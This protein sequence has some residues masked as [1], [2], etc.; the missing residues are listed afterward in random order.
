MGIEIRTVGRR[1]KYYLSH[2]YRANGEA[3]KVRVFLGTNL[4]AEEL[5]AERAGAAIRLKEKLVPKQIKRHK[6][7]KLVG[8]DLDGTLVYYPKAKSDFEVV[9]D[10]VG[11]LYYDRKLGNLYA[12]GKLSLSKWT[13]LTF[14]RYKERGLTQKK[15]NQTFK[16]QM[17]LI[18]GVR[19]L[20]EELKRR[21]I[22]V[23]IISGGLKNSYDAFVDKFGIE[24]DYTRFAHELVFDKKGRF[25]GGNYSEYD[26]EGKITT[27]Q[28]L[29]Q[30]LD[31]K[32]ENCAYVGSLINNAP[33]LKKVGLSIAFN[34]NNKKVIS[35]SK[36][37]IKEKDISKILEY[38]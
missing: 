30:D 11:S 12:K 21:K 35:A 31:I 6:V 4:T 23:V 9:D 20:F 38:L 16:K 7:I 13:E 5:N 26:Y 24:A 17:K 15:L 3:R 8:F 27:M 18:P 34:T 36:V 29:C 33:V 10:L 14:H 22:T 32:L 28:E 19:R 37:N 1:R 25:I 2:S